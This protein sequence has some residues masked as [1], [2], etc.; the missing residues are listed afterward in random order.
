V[1]GSDSIVKSGKNP[2]RPLFLDEI[3]ND[4]VVKVVDWSPLDLF[5][6]ILLLLRLESEL[7][8]NLLL[9]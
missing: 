1:G 8:E 9:Y 2:G 3:A 4:F 5:S 7:N 6:G